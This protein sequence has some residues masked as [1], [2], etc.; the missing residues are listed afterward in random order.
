ML[1]PERADIAR[2]VFLHHSLFITAARFEFTA[3]LTGGVVLSG[4]PMIRGRLS[5]HSPVRQPLPAVRRDVI[6]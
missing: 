2:F 4:V 6:L 1:S 3:P 5:V